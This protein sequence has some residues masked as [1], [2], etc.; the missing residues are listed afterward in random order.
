MGLELPSVPTLPAVPKELR[1]ME[2][3]QEITELGQILPDAPV[4]DEE[5]DAIVRR[6]KE[7]IEWETRHGIK[8]ADDEDDEDSDDKEPKGSDS[9][10]HDSGDEAPGKR[11]PKTSEKTATKAS[12]EDDDTILS[13]LSARFA[14]LGGMGKKSSATT[15][16]S[17]TPTDSTSPPSG[18]LLDL[19][20]VPTGLS[21]PSA[22]SSA[23]G[24][25]TPKKNKK[26]Q[27]EEVD[28]VDTWC[29][30]CTEDAEWRCEGCEGD[31]YCATCIY[32][33]HTGAEEKRHRWGRYVRPGRRLV[34][35]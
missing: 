26:K 6:I 15:S 7:E 22:P 20:S 9:D 33:A 4:D 27:E 23:P 17:I 16:K 2:E 25:S 13:K 1:T 12:K 35:A 34:G 31:I 29:C 21:L 8:D 24:T 28:E 10:N 5:A 32:E 19:P 3:K 11:K 18:G 30:I 14:A